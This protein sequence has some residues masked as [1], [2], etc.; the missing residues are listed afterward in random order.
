M[1]VWAME[2]EMARGLEGWWVMDE[3]SGWDWRREREVESK[4]LKLLK[5]TN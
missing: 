5:K 1:L 3:D 2:N 4:K